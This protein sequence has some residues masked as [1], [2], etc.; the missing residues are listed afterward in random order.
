MEACGPGRPGSAMAS[1]HAPPCGV[2]PETAIS[3]PRSTRPPVTAGHAGRIAGSARAAEQPLPMPPRS[4]AAPRSMRARRRD[5]VELDLALPRASPVERRRRV[6]RAA[7]R[8]GHSLP[9][10]SAGR[11]VGSNRPG[12]R[13]RRRAA[14]SADRGG[15]GRRR[16]PGLRLAVEAERPLVGDRIAKA[17]AH[18]RPPRPAPPP[19]LGG[20]ARASA[21]GDGDR[22][23]GI[24][25][26]SRGTAVWS[27]WPSI[28]LVTGRM[29]CDC[30]LTPAA[31]ERGAGRL[32]AGKRAAS[33]SGRR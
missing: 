31:G 33:E 11:I 6:P 3:P 10:S 30:L 22:D 17:P 19:G 23:G 8:S 12:P 1:R 27:S 13:G 20:P 5:R 18:R 32:G 15:A 25:C 7:R 21:T 4:T 29:R 26:P 14:A 9:R 28:R 2:A 16:R 24:P